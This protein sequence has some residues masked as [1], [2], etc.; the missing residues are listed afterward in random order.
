MTFYDVHPL[1]ARTFLFL[2]RPRHRQIT[3]DSLTRKIKDYTPPVAAIVQRLALVYVI[4][5]CLH[6]ISSMQSFVIRST[7][8][9]SYPQSQLGEL[10]K[11]IFHL[12]I[13]HLRS[14]M[15]CSN[16]IQATPDFAKSIHGSL[17]IAMF[18]IPLIFSN[19]GIPTSCEKQFLP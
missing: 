16:S 9:S 19:V 10:F 5:L 8:C 7:V 11:F 4:R 3:H 1:D 18:R 12:N 6:Q 15:T 13:I 17:I 2:K 14:T